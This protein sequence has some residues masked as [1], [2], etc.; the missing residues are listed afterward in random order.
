MR[1]RVMGRKKFK[2]T[3][4]I[5]MKTFAMRVNKREEQIISA[6][7]RHM[8]RTRSDAVRFVLNVAAKELNIEESRGQ[9]GK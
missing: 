7:A 1:E 9:N 6:L 5:R 3:G 8:S 2:D 4:N